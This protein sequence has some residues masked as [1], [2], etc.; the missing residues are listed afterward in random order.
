MGLLFQ[1]ESESLVSGLP[2][3]VVGPLEGA[4]IITSL[5]LFMRTKPEPVRLE[6]IFSSLLVL[7]VLRRSAQ[8]DWLASFDEIHHKTI[9]STLCT[10]QPSS[11]TDRAISSHE[12]VLQTRLTRARSQKEGGIITARRCKS[13]KWS[14]EGCCCQ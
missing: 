3:M 9:V 13:S 6:S 14:K 1:G 2:F 5:N 7:L 11:T 12:E 8:A 10:L 4:Y